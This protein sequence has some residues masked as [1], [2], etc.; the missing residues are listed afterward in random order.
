MAKPNLLA[1]RRCRNSRRPSRRFRS[2]RFE[3]LESRLLLTATPDAFEVDDTAEVAFDITGITSPQARS[4]HA[5]NDVDWAKFSL[6]EPSRVTLETAGVAGD[7]RMRLYGPDSS[8]YQIAYDYNSGEGNFSLIKAFLDPGEY[9]V[10]IEEYGQ[11]ATIDNYTL[12]FDAMPLSDL[13]DSYEADDTAQQATTLPTNGTAQTHSIH[14]PDDVDWYTFTLAEDSRVVLETDGVAGDTY[15]RLY[16][17]N[18]YQIAYDDRSGNEEFSQITAYLEAGTYYASVIEHYQDADIENYSIRATS[19]PLNQLADAY[20]PDDSALTATPIPLDGTPQAHNIHQPDDVDWFTFTLTE[21]SQVVLETD[22]VAGDTYMRLLDANQYQLAYDDRSGNE[23]FSKITAYLDPG[24]YYVNVI[25]QYQDAAIDSYTISAVA[26]SLSGFKDAYEPDNEF[27]AATPIALN[28]PPQTHSFH[29]PDDVDWLTFTLAEDS[30]VILETDGVDGNTYLRLFDS[31][32]SQVGYDHNGGNGYFSRLVSYLPAGTYTFSIQD[33]YEEDTIDAYTVT[34]LATPLSQLAD[35]FEPDNDPQNITNVLTPGVPQ[36]H[37]IHRWDDVDWYMFTLTEYSS[38]TID[39]TDVLGPDYTRMYFYEAGNQDAIVNASSYI[40]KVLAPGTYYLKITNGYNQTVVEHYDVELEVTPLPDLAVTSASIS[41]PGGLALNQTITLDWI[42]ENLGAGDAAARYDRFYLSEDTEYGGDTS[43]DS[44]YVGETL[45]SGQSQSFSLEVSLPQYEQF[46][47]WDGYLLVVTDAGDYLDEPNDTN[48]VYAIPISI[49]PVI[50]IVSPTFGPR[51]DTTNSFEI[52]WRAIDAN[53]TGPVRLAIDLDDDPNNGTGHYYLAPDEALFSSSDSNPQATNVVLPHLP[54][55]AEP[56]YLWARMS[57]PAGLSYSQPVPI[58][59]TNTVSAFAEDEYGDSVGSNDTYEVYGVDVYQNESL[60]HFRVRTNYDPLKNSYTGTG[61]GGGDVRVVI[62]GVPYGIA[63]NDHQA[64]TQP[65]TTGEL[66]VGAEFLGGAV[67]DEVPTF[68]DT[69]TSIIS[70]A[71]TVS[72]EQV[73][74]TTSANEWKFELTGTL[75]LALIPGYEY[76]QEVEISWAMYC[77]NDTDDVTIKPQDPGADDGKPDYIAQRIERYSDENGDGI[78]IYY[79]VETDDGLPAPV[80]QVAVYWATGNQP[81]DRQGDPVYIADIDPTPG[82]HGPIQIPE[83]LLVNQTEDAWYLQLV[84]DPQEE[85]AET[86]ED[87]NVALLAPQSAHYNHLLFEY[88]SREIVYRNDLGDYEGKL[89]ESVPN[90]SNVVDVG[91]WKID[92][93]WNGTLGFFAAAFTS[94]NAEPILVFRG[95]DEILD[96]MANTH[97][98]GIGIE[99]YQAHLPNVLDWMGT[100]VD[101]TVSLAGHSLGGA[102]AQW[103]AADFTEGGTQ[104]GEV[105]TFNAPGV[106]QVQA[107]KFRPQLAGGVTHY[108]VNG[109]VVSMGGE[110]FLTGQYIR[111][112]FDTTPLDVTGRHGLPLLLPYINSTDGQRVRASDARAEPANTT[113]WLNSPMYFHT[114]PDYL[115]MLAGINIF[116]AGLDIGPALLLRQTMEAE[117]QRLGAWLRDNLP[118]LPSPSDLEG[119]TLSFPNLSFSIGSFEVNASDLEV[120]LDDV[121]ETLTL[122]GKIELPGFY[123]D[124]T[125]TADFSGDNFIRYRPQVTGPVDTDPNDGWET[126]GRASIEN[127]VFVPDVWELKEAYI[128]IDTIANEI[129]GGGTI[130]I[131]GDVEVSGELGFVNGELSQITLGVEN[132]NKPILATG[133]FLQDISGDLQHIAA[134]DPEPIVFSGSV[135]ATYGPEITISLPSW[136]G[137][138]TWTTSLVDM[139]LEGSI[140]RDRLAASGVVEVLEGVAQAQANVEVN[141]NEGFLAATGQFDVLAG[142]IHTDSTLRADAD[143]NFTLAGNAIVQLPD[144]P[145]T[146]LDGQ[147]LGNAHTRV[148]YLHDGVSNN[149]FAAAWGTLDLGILGS[150]TVG[151]KVFLDGDW[152][153]IGDVSDLEDGS[154]LRTAE[155]A[156]EVATGAELL[157]LHVEWDGTAT[158][159]LYEIVDPNGIVYRAADLAAQPNMEE[160]AILSSA[161]SRAI[162]ILNPTPGSWTIRTAQTVDLGQVQ[163]SAYGDS[164]APELTIDQVEVTGSLAAV[165]FTAADSDS[166]A[167]IHF[168]V[169]SDAQGEGGTYLG[170]VN[171]NDSSGV[172]PFSTF[173]LSPG[174]YYIHAVIDDGS[175]APVTAD[176][177]I[178]FVEVQE[179]WQNPVLPEDVNADQDVDVQDALIL[180]NELLLNGARDLTGPPTGV[181]YDVQGDGDLDVVDAVIVINYLLNAAEGPQQSPPETDVARAPIVDEPTLDLTL[182]PTSEEALIDVVFT[183]Q[184]LADLQWSASVTSETRPDARR[185][186]LP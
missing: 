123:G 38:V 185:V 136:V 89:L 128:E 181:F 84:L 26:T 176:S 23:E 18:Q 3:S 103:F 69:Y 126:V 21:E 5:N 149:D 17:V 115:V 58:Y 12:S 168:Y 135:G 45:Q 143:W 6:S 109:D 118:S 183:D 177:A 154:V 51:I 44:H 83:T 132:L 61:Q 133:A 14:H 54:P 47:G 66:Y 10:R 32:Q 129:T 35:P 42:V 119:L 111:Y 72:Y 63:V 46:S 40:N 116:Y 101:A 70:G 104:I 137:G 172:F 150:R 34:A 117:R 170:S 93:V 102:L 167:T 148:Q 53:D 113:G 110:A 48:N 8:T 64:G 179:T 52:R 159:P 78:N 145:W 162:G 86:H 39:T 146:P 161:N 163:F 88:L 49:A 106:S 59:V 139:T 62:D 180:I 36:S 56:Y 127:L 75:D 160:I 27:A 11:N 131:P 76:E 184:E 140:D 105:V 169:S 153:I 67:V 174:G 107:D 112:N 98:D 28:A 124:A 31:N 91:G 82:Q 164:Q 68:I 142:L 25:E 147:T 79:V 57:S 24:T 43:L 178:F 166:Q 97:P 95:T 71:T 85:V 186:L 157:L 99:Q 171:E 141:W 80:T 60:L 30:K 55:R 165:S 9:Y 2:R 182:E 144:I 15:M 158:D 114:D 173:G 100:Q 41:A 37:S 13:A 74:E 156:Y 7:T 125:A 81:E 155:H 16:N 151:F 87:N 90:Q 19:T 77:G 121:T 4:I 1:S 94:F 175:S 92:K 134:S 73:S 96:W 33:Y 130:L 20:E 65:V 50:E 22:G 122:Q 152:D 108:I 138:Y 29:R 120:S